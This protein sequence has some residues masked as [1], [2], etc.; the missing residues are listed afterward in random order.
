MASRV[1]IAIC[2][3]TRMVVVPTRVP[4]PAEVAMPPARK[5]A[6]AVEALPPARK[7]HPQHVHRIPMIARK[8]CVSVA[9]RSC[10]PLHK[11]LPSCLHLRLLILRIAMLVIVALIV[12]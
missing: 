1:A 6:P 3:P 12:F 8:P 9:S 4:A 11:S 7:Q 10:V 2:L 5:H